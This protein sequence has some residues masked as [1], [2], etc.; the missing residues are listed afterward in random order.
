MGPS[1]AEWLGKE[2]GI[3]RFQDLLDHF[4]FRYIDRGEVQK[5]RDINPLSEYVQVRGVITQVTEM[6]EGRKKRLVAEVRDPTGTI[7]LV[8]FAGLQ[9]LKK[10]LNPGQAVRVFGRLNSVG[11]FLSIPHPELETDLNQNQTATGWQPLYPTTEKLRS[12]SLTNSSLA[13]LTRQL[14][15]KIQPSDLPEWMPSTLL[16][17][18]GLCSRYS[19]YQWIHFPPDAEHLERARH[20]LKVEELLLLQ[21][22]I[23]QARAI[24]RRIPGFPFN[25]VGE[26]FHRFYRESLPFSLTEAQKRVLREIRRDCGSGYQMNRLLQGDVGSGKTI[27][28]LMAMLLALDNGFQ[29]CLMAPTEILAQQHYQSIRRMLKGSDIPTALLTGS[30]KGKERSRIL[31]DLALGNLPLILGTHALIEE[32]IKFKNLGLAVIDEQHRFGVGQ[33]AQL[34][35][36]NLQPPHILVMTATPIPRTLAMTQYGDLDLSVIDERPAGRKEIRTFWR[37][38]PSRAQF[39]DFIRKQVDAGYQAYI[40]YPLI[41]ESEK[42]DY[43]SLMA[44]YEQVKVFFSADPY[45]VAMVHGRQPAEERQ[46]N[47]ERFQRGEAQILVATTVIE[48]GVDV[49]NATVMLIESAERFGLSQLHQLQS[50][51]GRGGQ[52]S[53][54]LLLTSPK[55]S[56]ESRRRMQVMTA[57]SDGFRIAEEDLAIRGPGDLYGTRQSGLMPLKI[58]DLVVD[59]PLVEQTREAARQIMEKDPGLTSPEHQGLRAQIGAKTGHR[60]WGQIG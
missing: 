1:R 40:V 6:G 7:D 43:E 37:S 20:R 10:S 32:K 39:M 22:Q 38:D 33:R 28:A 17:S 44:G 60:S 51:M 19:A 34:W 57:T 8:W 52:Q 18:F 56:S 48:V 21:I 11:G 25:T 59:L 58:A 53:Y 9:R 30:V 35:K 47:M 5:I 23:A 45:R 26:R 3:Y 24:R 49:P 36:K 4:P 16:A 29:A 42:L 14:I 46:R 13:K 54:C 31:E 55:I 15:A 41:E 27:V 2:L 50:R 12:R